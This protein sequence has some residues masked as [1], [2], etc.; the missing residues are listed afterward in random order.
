MADSGTKITLRQMV[1]RPIRGQIS[2]YASWTSGWINRMVGW[3]GVDTTRYDRTDRH[4][5]QY[6]TTE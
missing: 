4:C 2:T 3:T 1:S 6:R 5:T